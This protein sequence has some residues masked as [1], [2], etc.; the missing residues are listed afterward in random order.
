MP[1]VLP[2]DLPAFESLRSEGMTVAAE[3][4]RGVACKRVLLLNLMP[5]KQESELDAFRAMYHP[6]MWVEFHLIKM[7]GLRYKTTPQE[8]MDR[9]YEDI[10]LL[11][12][13]GEWY[14]GLFV[15]GAPLQDLAFEEVIYWQ[16][17]Q[18]FFHWCDSHV[19]HSLY[20][21]WGAFARTFY[22][23]G[24]RFHHNGQQW[25]GVYPCRIVTRG[26]G[27]VDDSATMVPSPVSRPIYY[28]R[29]QLEAQP[30]IRIILDNEEV[31]PSLYMSADGRH[32]FS[33]NHPEYGPGRL[34]FEYRRDLARGK[35]PMRPV[36]YYASDDNDDDIRF[37]W[38][39]TRQRLYHGWLA[40]L[41]L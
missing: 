23:W 25:S 1:L 10:A 13:R 33:L 16:Q 12:A 3:A 27:L 2:H 26:T 19:G 14:D 35:H 22:M 34:D 15:N 5:E 31:G 29:E 8:Y 18:E 21:C 32:V 40:L 37:T 9:H 6:E 30:D 36:G 4:P 11:M 28:R 39:D 20:V 24:L 17:L 41:C 7:T 38:L